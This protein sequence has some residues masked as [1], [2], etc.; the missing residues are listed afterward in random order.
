MKRAIS[1]I[2]VVFFLFLCTAAGQEKKD[3]DPLTVD[4]QWKGKLTQ[5]GKIG[6]MKDIPPEF[7]TVLVVTKRT[8]NDFE[9]E[10]RE[11]VGES[12]VTYLCKG[13]VAPGEK[14]SFK[15]DF[16]STA[17]KSANETFV[18]VPQVPYTGTISGKTLKGTWKLSAPKDDTEI[19]GEFNFEKQ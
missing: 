4:S 12:F 13:K 16:K 11:K 19:E 8:D 1:P 17:V 18:S 14:G 9:C 2:F 5:K 6:G 7:E 3:A 15:V 10:L